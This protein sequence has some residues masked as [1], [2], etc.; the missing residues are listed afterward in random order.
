MLFL[1]RKKRCAGSSP[2]STW[3]RIGSAGCERGRGL[4]A[5][6][7]VFGRLRFAKKQASSARHPLAGSP[8]RGNRKQSD[9]RLSFSLGIPGRLFGDRLLAGLW[10]AARNGLDASPDSRPPTFAGA[11]PTY[12]GAPTIAVHPAVS[13]ATAPALLPGLAMILRSRNTPVGR[14]RVWP[15]MRGKDADSPGRPN[16]SLGR[17]QNVRTYY[18]R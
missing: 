3:F 6:P 12:S 8:G 5:S 10:P 14:H 13:E 4:R 18:D 9:S 11:V 17:L 2:L 15:A 7:E 16:G 1:S